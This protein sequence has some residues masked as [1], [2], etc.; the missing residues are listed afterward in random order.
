M[1]I[2]PIAM[3]GTH[4]HFL[5][6]FV[7]TEGHEGNGLKV[8]DIGAGHGAFSQKLYE[9]G[10]NV[11]A[12]DLFPEL[13]EFDAIPCDKVDVAQEF[14]YPD[15]HFDL[16]IAIEVMEH[17][18]GQDHFFKEANR[19]LKPGGKLFF[20]TPNILSLKSRM[21]FLL[22]GFYYSFGPLDYENYNGL[23]H[24]SSLTF[25]QFNYWAV[26]NGFELAELATDKLQNSS[27]W[28]SFLRPF[29]WLYRQRKGISAIHNQSTLLYGRKLFLT[30]R[31]K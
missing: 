17:F 23:Q 4:K 19:L 16:L 12:C 27:R 10:Y 2:S 20:T 24:V 5:K 30:Y 29:Q 26:K 22:G 31:K 18:N 25:D 6:H 9:M 15:A 1:S 14:P 21:R 11:A 3:P 7:R 28:L 8:L 13:F